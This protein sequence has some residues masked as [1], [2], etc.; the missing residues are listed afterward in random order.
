M[1]ETAGEIAQW[2]KQLPGKQKVLNL[3][4]GTEKENVLK[5]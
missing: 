5:I 3:I 4:P 1:Y 2:C